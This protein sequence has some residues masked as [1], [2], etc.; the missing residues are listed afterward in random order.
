[1]T[2]ADIAE[3]LGARRTGCGRWQ[4]RCPAHDDKS[5]SLS[6]SEGS[7][8]RVLLHC[9]AG[10]TVEAMLAALGLAWHDLFAGPPPTPEQTRLAVLMR[11]KYE[12]EARQRCIAH[13]AA[14]ERMLRLE[15]I[16]DELGARLARAQD[17]SKI[18]ELFYQVTDQLHTAEVVEEGLRP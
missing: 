3:L 10:C 9:H 11:D 18:A 4:A 1:M 2:A 6:I 8:G 14:C 16:A 5:P 13:G 7:D 17:N 15:R 12:T